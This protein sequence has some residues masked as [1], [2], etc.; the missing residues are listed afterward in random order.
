MFKAITFRLTALPLSVRFT[1]AA[2]LLI[3]VFSL[4]F[5]Y[6]SLTRLSSAIR[7]QYL[8]RAQAIAR[9]LADSSAYFVAIGDRTQLESLTRGLVSDDLLY[10]E[11]SSTVPGLPIT[12]SYPK[13]PPFPLFLSVSD[14]PIWR[15]TKTGTEYLYPI[16]WREAS[17]VSPEEVLMGPTAPAGQPVRVGFVRLAFSGEPV[18]AALRRE[19]SIILLMAFLI[20]IVGSFFTRVLFLQ[21]VHPV[22]RLTTAV[23]EFA[24]GR[25]PP[26]I[27]TPQSGEIKILV[28]EFQMM[29]EVLRRREDELRQI[30]RELAE[31]NRV[32]STFLASISH[33][34]KTPL[35]A[36]IGY[37]QLLLEG[38]EGPLTSEQEKDLQTVLGAGKHLLSLISQILEYARIEAGRET[39]APEPFTLQDLLR[40]CYEI[41]APQVAEKRIQFRLSLP[42]SWVRLLADPIKIRQIILNLLSNALKFT[43]SGFITLSAS[44]DDK[45]VRISV[46]D[47]GPGIPS[48]SLPRVFEPFVVL[49]SELTRRHGGAGLGL[50][51]SSSYAH[52]HGGRLSACSELGKGATFTL[53]IPFVIPV[54]EDEP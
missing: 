26:R 37:A 53:E 34:L 21:V 31:A 47:T 50:A 45:S 20:L 4:G 54:G 12:V 18:R 28:D 7:T 38:S 32:K 11:I 52:L 27:R 19:H 49:D 42:D 22:T 17:P 2:I 6:L 23:Q 46:Q 30:N 3:L 43:E 8:S 39:L 24:Q 14:Q 36:I 9:T 35:H 10:T 5:F 48:E 44:A 15:S 25:T 41:F 33:E 13:A 29:T 16:Y 40:E 51:I 1:V